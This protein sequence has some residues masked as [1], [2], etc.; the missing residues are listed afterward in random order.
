MTTYVVT[1]KSDG[2]EVYRYVA[3]APIEWV[4]FEF[5]GFTHEALADPGPA[6]DPP[7]VFV[8]DRLVFMRRFDTAERIAARER[9]K[10]DTIMADF[11]DL[12]RQSSVVHSND[13]DVIAGLGYMT[14]VGILAAGRATEIL[15][16][17]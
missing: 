13:P 9:E 2:Q 4:G 1:R 6:S 16:G 15:G 3:D 14:A 5:A 8:W 11:F 12:L 10:T 7:P 17:A